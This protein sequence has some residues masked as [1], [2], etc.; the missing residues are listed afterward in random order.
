MGTSLFTPALS[1]HQFSS[2]WKTEIDGKQNFVK[3]AT[4]DGSSKLILYVTANDNFDSVK[5]QVLDKYL[6][7]YT[8]VESVGQDNLE[9]DGLGLRT[10]TFKGKISNSNFT[11]TAQFAFVLGVEPVKAVLLIAA[12]RDNA[13]AT[14][15]AAV[16][17]VFAGEKSASK[18][19]ASAAPKSG[20]KVTIDVKV[21][22][23]IDGS[24]AQ[25]KARF[26]RA[27]ERLGVQVV[28]SDAPDVTA[29]HIECGKDDN[30]DDND[31]IAD[32]KDSDDNNDGV[33]DAKQNIQEIS[34]DAEA[35]TLTDDFADKDKSSGIYFE[36]DGE[37]GID[38]RFESDADSLDEAIENTKQAAA[39]FNNDGFFQKASFSPAIN[40]PLLIPSA[41]CL[42][43]KMAL[44]ATLARCKDA[45]CKN[46]VNS[47]ANS[48]GCV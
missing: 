24:A 47:R 19:T 36:I 12:V 16:S 22:D 18:T 17:E 46:S 29:L 14:N 45:G 26:T 1:P 48:L 11:I 37:D 35:G 41:D 6:A 33:D 7:Q 10:D 20:L 28:A 40:F 42:R 9:R 39:I 31:G 38:Q 8:D 5:E 44:R 13:E 25:V 4:A 43:Q 30:D 27:F 21:F 23:D 2:G 3:A 34:L 32:A 15:G